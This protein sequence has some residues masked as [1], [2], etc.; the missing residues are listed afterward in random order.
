MNIKKDFPIFTNNPGLIYMDSTSS[1]QKPSLVIEWIKDY[2]ENNCS[3]IHRGMYDIAEKS[4]K[5]YDDSKKKVCELIWWS[6][7]KEVI[8]TY[9]S[10]YA[11]NIITQSLRLSN[12][13]QK[14]DKVLIS[15]VEHHANIVPWLI[16]KEE[17]GIEVEYIELDKNYNLDFEDFEKKYDDKV[18]IISMTHVSNV[19]GQIFDLERVW[20]LKRDDTLFIVDWSQSI[21]HFEVDVKKIN[22][23]FL[24]FTAHKI[25][26]ETWL[27]ILWW[28]KELL[29]ELK[30]I[31]SGGWAIW[32]VTEDSFNYAKLPYK[33]EPG[34]PNI[35]WAISLL[36]AIEYIEEIWWFKKIEKIE[37]DLVEY[38][39]EKFSERKEIKIIWSNNSKNRVWVF[40]FM[41]DTIHSDDIADIMA[42]NNICIRSWMHCAHPFLKKI[43]VAHTSRMSLYIYNTREEIDKFFEVLDFIIKKLTK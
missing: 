21:P 24:F 14:W 4:E 33:F 8:Y 35:I 3:N 22:A 16:L 41:I 19:T 37:N 42:E 7:Y 9:N 40:S 12:K 23:D 31:F 18:K 1:T 30:P 26:A 13:L 34:T 38:T 20:K 10:T 15:I 43:D 28:K 5:V 29:E 17:I 27:W 6:S 25:L 36:K 11:A 2:L 32:R 39:L